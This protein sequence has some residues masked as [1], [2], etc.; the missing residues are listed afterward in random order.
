MP[1]LIS[2]VTVVQSA[3]GLGCSVE[4]S[5][6]LFK[7]ATIERLLRHWQRLLEGIAI[8]PE[9]HLADL[10][11]LTTEELQLL[12]IQW[13]ATMRPLSG[14]VYFHHLVEEQAQLQADTVALMHNDHHL[15]YKALNDLSN[16]LALALQSRDVGPDVLVGLCLPRSLNW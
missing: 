6:D 11:L 15:T 4:Y 2:R 1:S 16:C 10:P 8:R 7:A 12:L 13:N 14:E 5:T 3:H 9:A